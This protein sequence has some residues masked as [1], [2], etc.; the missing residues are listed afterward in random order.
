MEKKKSKEINAGRI[1]VVGTQGGGKSATVM[2]LAARTDSSME[3]YEDFSGTIETEYLKVSFD[4]GTF[5]SL[6]LPIGGQEKWAKLR[7]RFGSTA[8]AIVTILD[9]CT[10]QFWS[11]SLQQATSISTVLPYHNYPVSFIVT[12]KDLN[13]SISNDAGVF[14]DT[15][16]EGV[17][18]AKREGVTYFSRGFRISERRF[19]I[20]NELEE[21]PFTQ[22]EQIIVNALEQKYFTGLEPGNARRGKML[23][24]GFSLVNCRIFSRALTLALSHQAEPGDQ[25]AILGLLNDMRPTMLELDTNWTD[26]R[27]KYPGAGSEPVIPVNLSVEEIKQIILE[28]LLANETDISNFEKEIT[29]MSYLTGWRHVGSEHISIFEEAGLDKASSLVKRIMEA[30]SE[31]EPAHK[32][33]LFDP[34]EELF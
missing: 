19:E 12:K 8:E 18:S 21:I 27:Q 11:N 3:Y 20:N 28:K 22:M 1:L 5:Y 13:E 6:L 15:I 9:S 29:N 24:D 2:K 16:V 32:F 26:L 33:T 17:A 31:S 7:E 4:E 25:V 34:I 23:L 30:I 14:G 10:K